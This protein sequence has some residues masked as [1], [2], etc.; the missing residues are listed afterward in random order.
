MCYLVIIIFFSGSCLFCWFKMVNE[1]RL[2]S[3]SH[4]ICPIA[5]QANTSFY[6]DELVSF[7]QLFCNKGMVGR[8]IDLK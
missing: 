6:D 4:R 8:L 2:F 3:V 5:S 1:L 7:R